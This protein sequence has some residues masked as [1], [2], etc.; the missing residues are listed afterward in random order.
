VFRIS[1]FGHTRIGANPRVLS[2]DDLPGLKPRQLLELLALG[3]G[4]PVAKTVLAD[5]LWEGR[6]PASWPATVEGYVSVLRRCL[7]PGVPGR[8]TLI[9]TTPGGYRIDLEHAEID[10]ELFHRLLAAASEAP[11]PEALALL[12]RAVQLADA[13]LLQDEVFP[14]WAVEARSA[15][16][17]ARTTAALRGAEAALGADEPARAATLA[18]VVTDGEPL[19]ERGWQLAIEALGRAGRRAEAVCA[20]HECRAVLR[21]DLGIDPDPLTQAVFLRALEGSWPAARGPVDPRPAGLD[22]YGAL[23][24]PARPQTAAPS[25]S[26]APTMAV[27]AAERRSAPRTSSRPARPA[28]S[29]RSP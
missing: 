7:E 27:A 12:E 22:P 4:A 25:R 3:R 20:Y 19:M 16:R 10:L 2:A 28:S 17:V 29:P 1:L 14:R 15:A 21:R 26:R 8:H 24:P 9:K 6:P 18:G 11:A 5:R 23:W 13:N